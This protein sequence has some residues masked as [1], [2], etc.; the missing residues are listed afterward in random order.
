MKGC[1]MLKQCFM[2]CL[3][4]ARCCKAMVEITG[5]SMKDCFSLPGL[6]W[7]HFNRLRTEEGEPVYTYID[8]KCDVFSTEF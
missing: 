6:R 5:F 7:K 1:L 8:K 3:F 4:N 2:Y